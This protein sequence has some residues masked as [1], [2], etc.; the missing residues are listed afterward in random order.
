MAQPVDPGAIPS[1]DPSTT[2]D[3]MKTL[4][5]WRWHTAV[6]LLLLFTQAGFTLSRTTIMVSHCVGA[7][8]PSGVRA[9]GCSHS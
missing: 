3:Q 7:N 2:S 1:P 9:S 8:V 4:T 6:A 5:R